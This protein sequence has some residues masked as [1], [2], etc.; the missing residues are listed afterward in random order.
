MLSFLFIFVQANEAQ[1]AAALA[2]AASIKLTLDPSLPKPVVC[3]IRDLKQNLSKRVCVYGWAHRIRRQGRT[4]MFIILRD[5]TGFLQCVL[6]DNL[7]SKH[8][9]IMIIQICKNTLFPVT[10]FA[11]IFL[12]LTTQ[13]MHIVHYRNP[14]L[15]QRFCGIK[16][17]TLLK[18]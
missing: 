11:C 7:V 16:M 10:A 6:S 14:L 4:L 18:R 1:S 15:T 9:S 3:K 17:E 13:V 8:S 2:E 5:G 12:V